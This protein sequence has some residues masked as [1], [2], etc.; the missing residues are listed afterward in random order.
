MSL[1]WPAPLPAPVV[2]GD[3]ATYPGVRAGQDLSVTATRTGYELHLVV[4]SRPVTAP[5][6][7]MP[8]QVL[9]ADVERSTDGSL[10]LRD[11]TGAVI[12]RGSRPSM[13]DASVDKV[14]GLPRREMK[15]G[16]ALR[17]SAGAV[18]SALRSAARGPEGSAARTSGT[19]EA[20]VDLSWLTDPAT[21]YPV[22]VDPDVNFVDS[23]DTYVSSTEHSTSHDS[24]TRLYVGN[25]GTKVTRSFVAF[26]MP[27]T[28]L[29]RT[30]VSAHVDL[31]NSYSS[32]CA[33][34]PVVV[35]QVTAPFTSATTWDNQPGW[36]TGNNDQASFSHGSTSCPDGGAYGSVY[37]TDLVSAWAQGTYSTYQLRLSAAEIGVQ[38]WKHFYASE[39][40]SGQPH[41]YLTY[42]TPPNAPTGLDPVAG[43]PFRAS[44]IAPSAI[45]S[46]PDGGYVQGR[47]SLY[48]LSTGTWVTST[49]GTLGSTVVSGGRTSLIRGRRG[50]VD[51]ERRVLDARRDEQLLQRRCP[52]GPRGAL[53]PLDVS[54]QRGGGDRGQAGLSRRRE[55]GGP[56]TAQ[57]VDR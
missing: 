27:S 9:G 46:D 29:G 13:W 40:G 25:D 41:L 34:N 57:P 49:A 3:T 28:L 14:T 1:S 5:V 44:S 8:L 33:A 6:L 19:V 54:A 7:S 53:R 15:L 42:D 18:V 2:T 4:R 39:A 38:G 55:L 24:L 11:G 10:Q 31:F 30:I 20:T 22:T 48:N 35:Q 47:F 17:D 56:R 45:I 21:V 32:T 36:Y 43:S 23:L 50:P 52:R 12:A 16:Q 26:P 37:I 51:V